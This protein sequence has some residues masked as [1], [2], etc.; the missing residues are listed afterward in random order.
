LI[1]L[2]P[3]SA[4]ALADSATTTSGKLDFQ[5]AFTVPQIQQG[6][7]PGGTLVLYSSATGALTSARPDDPVEREKR[8]DADDHQ[9]AE[10]TVSLAV[11]TKWLAFLTAIIAGTAFVQIWML[12]RQLKLT[13]AADRHSKIAADAAKASADSLPRIE[14]A[15][16]FASISFSEPLEELDEDHEDYVAANPRAVGEIK[17]TITNHGKTPAVLTSL[18]RYPVFSELAPQ[19]LVSQNEKRI[20]V[21]DGVVVAG[22]KPFEIRIRLDVDG[23]RWSQLK[24]RKLEMFCVG[25]ITYDDVLGNSHKTG[26]CWHAYDLLTQFPGFAITRN[27]KLN[28]R[29]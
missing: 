7:P 28:I 29:T 15:Y 18:D 3:F 12:I 9:L 6:A 27:T 20:Q 5:K 14:R 10:S 21:P 19:L 1:G 23:E 2:S 4:F 16:L 25:A 13:E 22:D 8:R 24:S 11:A 26:F 17:V